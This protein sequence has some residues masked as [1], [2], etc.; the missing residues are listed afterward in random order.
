MRRHIRT[1]DGTLTI[2][3]GRSR[4][5]GELRAYTV[6]PRCIRAPTGDFRRVLEDLLEHTRKLELEAERGWRYTPNMHNPS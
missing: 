4:T 5:P 1:A 2:F 6:G 3:Y